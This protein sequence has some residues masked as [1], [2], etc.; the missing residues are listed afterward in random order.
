MGSIVC[1]FRKV[2]TDHHPE[3]EVQWQL[4]S[5]WVRLSVKMLPSRED[6]HSRVPE[7]SRGPG[8]PT[9]Q[10]RH[11]IGECHDVRCQCPHSA[12]APGA[13]SAT[14]VWRKISQD[15]A[16]ACVECRSFRFRFVRVQCPLDWLLYLCNA[17]LDTNWIGIEWMDII[18]V[19]TE[20]WNNLLSIKDQIF[21]N[22][23]RY[24]MNAGEV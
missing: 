15:T 19:E 12:P 7:E 3:H 23:D 24:K 9:S 13:M 10:P 1:I 21:D 4:S 17:W 14:S 22:T 8:P 16:D 18:I 20:C 2:N 11:K 6:N 5:W